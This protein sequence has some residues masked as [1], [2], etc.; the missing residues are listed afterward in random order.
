MDIFVYDF[1]LH[2]SM[3]KKIVQTILESGDKQNKKTNVQAYMTDWN[4]QSSEITCFSRWLEN[5]IYWNLDLMPKFAGKNNSLTAKLQQVDCWGAVYNRGDYTETHNH[6]LNYLS[7][8]YF[9]NTPKGS[10]PL[11][12]TTSNKKIKAEE[13][14]VIIFNSSINHHVP[15]NKCDDR[16]IIAGNY[17]VDQKELINRPL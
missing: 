3:K 17:T 8:V 1:D 12:F 9:V 2:Y 6:N 11:V 13:G 5:K 15:K 10:S 14:K 16:I 7:F 4:I